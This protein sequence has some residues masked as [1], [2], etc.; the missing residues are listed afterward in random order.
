VS[1]VEGREQQ[2]PLRIFPHWTGKGRD[3][4]SRCIQGWN[5]SCL[6]ACKVR[7]V[8]RIEETMHNSYT[9]LVVPVLGWLVTV[10]LLLVGYLVSLTIEEKRHNRRMN[11]E[12]ERLGLNG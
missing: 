9:Y 6:K 7:H 11:E 8:R 1:G 3:Q 10:S 12:R 4:V 2:A 5:A